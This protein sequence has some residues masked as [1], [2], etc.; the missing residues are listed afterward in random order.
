DSSRTVLQRSS[1]ILRKLLPFYIAALVLS[2]PFV[3]GLFAYGLAHASDGAI[4]RLLGLLAALIVLA[5]VPPLA[6]LWRRNSATM[7]VLKVLGGIVMLAA[8]AGMFLLLKFW[9]LEPQ[10]MKLRFRLAMNAIDVVSVSEEPIDLQ[11][12]VIGLKVVRELDL[13]RR[14]ALDRYGGHVLEAIREVF[15]SPVGAPPD[16]QSPFD[17]QVSSRLLAIDDAPSSMSF[18]DFAR[19]SATHLPAGRYRTEHVI[20]LSGLRA[21]DWPKPPCRD[22]E[23]LT[24][25]AAS[26]GKASGF[27]LQVRS[28]A[29]L[30]LES[31]RG[32]DFRYVPAMPLKY[33]YE[34]SSWMRGVQQLPIASC[35][36]QDE[37]EE[38]AR[39]AVQRAEKE[40][41]YSEGDS[42]L[43][44]DENPLFREMCANELDAVRARLAR[45][46]PAFNLSGKIL[47]CTITQPQPEMF[48]VLMPALYA[49]KQERGGY[50]SIVRTLHSR[51]ALAY[52]D[53]LASVD[54]PLVCTSAEDPPPDY[55][56]TACNTNPAPHRC[57][58]NTFAAEHMWRAG[59][60]PSDA[61]G[62]VNRDVASRNDT[63]Q[64]LQL[65][66]SHDIAICQTLPDSTNLLHELVARSSPEVVAFLVKAGCDAHVRPPLDVSP[67]Y[68]QLQDSSAARRWFMRTHGI[69]IY[70][71][72]YS[73]VDPVQG[74]AIA[75]AMGELTPSDINHP[76]AD[77]GMSLL[78][79]LARYL[80]ER[81]E[82]LRYLLAHG[83]RLD[84]ADKEG[85]SWFDKGYTQILGRERATE[86]D[87]ARLLS[88]L[89]QLSVSQLRELMAPKNSLS[90]EP[91]QPIE[92]YDF[93]PGQLT[94]YLCERG[95][96]KCTR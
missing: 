77:S 79:R 12:R 90:G 11:G 87:Q 5:A 66:H 8:C 35:K 91:G 81:P 38:A 67:E 32:Y 51:R 34:H 58:A 54:L 43:T 46:T 22:D 93:A 3:L 42:R 75:R 17:V 89:D 59:V 72:E 16:A 13:K 30:S 76:S 6:L 65:L 15:I 29:R 83:A 4:T 26:L 45:G 27:A 88:M 62:W 92:E 94:I 95:A 82:M 70:G 64:W 21:R 86:A 84:V 53:K 57:L 78:H 52:L 9:W 14:I 37:Q 56:R 73:P 31:R 63:L 2:A 44:A 80:P 60:Y 10:W 96:R 25:A 69:A 7:V 40:R 68:I 85:R 41:W 55:R 36:Q 28:A 48:A 61:S 71:D 49:R 18:D 23:L 1:S 39:A 20:L 74:R 47:D 19:G 33:R 24:R 50:C